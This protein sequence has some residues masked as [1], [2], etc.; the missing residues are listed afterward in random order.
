MIPFLA[1]NK[2]ANMTFSKSDVGQ[3]KSLEGTDLTLQDWR[4]TDEGLELEIAYSDT[5]NLEEI[6]EWTLPDSGIKSID[7]HPYDFRE[8]TTEPKVLTYQFNK[9]MQ[10]D[11]WLS[12]DSVTITTIKVLQE[13]PWTVQLSTIEEY[14]LE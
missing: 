12:A 6:V 5:G 1:Y 8:T 7:L 9:D 3:T 4:V 13:G 10:S 14:G 11:E 2:E